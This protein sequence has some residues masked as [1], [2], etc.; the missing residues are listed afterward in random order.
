[1]QERTTI[2]GKYFSRVGE[3]AEQ[4]GIYLKALSSE[5]FQLLMD[6]SQLKSIID[7]DFTILSEI[8]RI[9]NESHLQITGSLGIACWDEN[10]VELG[11]RVNDALD[12]AFDR[13]GDQAVVNIQGQPIQYFGG[14][15]ETVEKRSR[16]KARMISGQLLELINQSKNV[17]VMSHAQP[18]HDALGAMVG[19]MKLAEYCYKDVRIVVDKETMD[20]SVRQLM[21]EL[22]EENDELSNIFVYKDQVKQFMSDDTLIVIVDTNNPGILYSPDLLKNNCKRVIIDHH[23]RG[24]EM[25]DKTELLYIEPYASSSVELIVELMQFYESELNITS[26]EATLMY[27]GIIVDTNNFSYRTGSRTFDAASFLRLYGAN[28]TKVQMYLRENYEDY[29]TQSR[30]LSSAELYLDRFS[31]VIADEELSRVALAK[32][33]DRL[34]MIDNVDAAFVVGKLSDNIVGITAR[35]FGDINVQVLMERFNGGGHLHNAAAQ[36]EMDI[37]EC[38]EKL[39]GLLQEIREGG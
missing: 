4:N 24:K 28:L 37:D 21:I 39:K 8:R 27:I 20:I 19:I 12:N 33:S 9:S 38:Y 34:L 15:S 29:M 30:L 6:Y 23:R 17:L 11:D 1:V 32:L 5:K 35:S 31:L 7:D 14:V 36:V 26:T 10:Y 25:V 16:V 2:Q 18:D 3:W 13:G 22:L